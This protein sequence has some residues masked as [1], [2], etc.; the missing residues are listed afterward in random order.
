MRQRYLLGILPWIGT[1]GRDAFHEPGSP[2][3]LGGIRRHLLSIP[4]LATECHGDSSRA[5]PCRSAA[6]LADMRRQRAHAGGCTA[7]RLAAYPD[8]VLHVWRLDRGHFALIMSF[9]LN[10]SYVNA[11]RYD[12]FVCA[13]ARQSPAAG[14]RLTFATMRSA[15][16]T[17]TE[18]ASGLLASSE[19]ACR[20]AAAWSGC[21][22]ASVSPNDFSDFT[23]RNRYVPITACHG[24]VSAPCF[25]GACTTPRAPGSRRAGGNR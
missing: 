8:R 19:W 7:A 23:S 15:S 22:A 16:Q 17:S 18:L 14:F 3:E 4:L 12:S 24:Q 10:K 21:S 9:E 6:L 25:S 1:G 11:F 5:C 13:A 2:Q 20:M